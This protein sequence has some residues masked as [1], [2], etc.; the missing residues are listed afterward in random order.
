MLTEREKRIKDLL[1]SEMGGYQSYSE[2]RGIKDQIDPDFLS[3]RERQLKFHFYVLWSVFVA[4]LFAWL[5][6]IAYA[7]LIVKKL[8]LISGIFVSISATMTVMFAY[9]QYQKK[10]MAFGVFEILADAEP[11]QKQG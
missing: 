7:L 10:K 5:G 11:E 4:F 2:H 8:S 9:A 6:M 1:A 3:Q